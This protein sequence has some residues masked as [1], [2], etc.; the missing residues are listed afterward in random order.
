MISGNAG[1]GRFAAPAISVFGPTAKS[2]EILLDEDLDGTKIQI[3]G[4]D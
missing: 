1:V 4:G 2:W 3:I